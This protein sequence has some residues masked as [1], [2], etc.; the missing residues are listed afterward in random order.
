MTLVKS[1]KQIRISNRLG[2]NWFVFERQKTE[3]PDMQEIHRE[4]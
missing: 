2:E 4:S 1:E 3:T